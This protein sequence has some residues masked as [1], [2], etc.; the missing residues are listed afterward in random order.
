V[1]A[2]GE[3]DQLGLSRAK[4]HPRGLTPLVEMT[5]GDVELCEVLRL[6]GGGRREGASGMGADRPIIREECGRQQRAVRV[7]CDGV[8]E[9]VNEDEEEEG[10]EYTPLRHS[11]LDIHPSGI[12]RGIH[13]PH[14]SVGEEGTNPLPRLA[15]DARIVNSLQEDV[16]IDPVEC[17]LD[18]EEE[19]WALWCIPRPLSPNNP[20]YGCEEVIDSV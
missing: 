1:F 9:V 5:N 11:I 20:L 12:F 16:V 2:S 14:A 13:A 18:V 4:P 6:E 19:H 10:A 17:F 8:L 3:D 15:R 7:R